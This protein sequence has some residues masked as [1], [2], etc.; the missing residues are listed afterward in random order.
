[1]IRP[2]AQASLVTRKPT[3]NAQERIV[4]HLQHGGRSRHE[5]WGRVA[6]MGVGDFSLCSAWSPY[7]L[8]LDAHEFLVVD[9]PRVALEQRLPSLD[10]LIARRIPGSTPSGRLLHNFILSLWQQG[11]QSH[12]DP[13]WQQGV[14]NVFLDLVCLAVKGAELPLVAPQTLRERVFRAVEANL[15][16]PD[17]CSARLAEEVGV[18]VRT[19]QN[20]F[21]AMGTTPSGYILARRLARASEL[22]TVNPDMSITAI[23]FE[24]GFSESGY[25]ARC[26]RQHFGAT[27]TQW[28]AGH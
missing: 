7:R 2:R 5:Q 11:S 1:M 19:I 4:L 22:L 13:E 18:S 26:F 27:P 16:D 9:M 12:A 21:A 20:V 17:V 23:A 25:L 10:D 6:E 3:G 8:D 28:R 14:A 24:L 15:S